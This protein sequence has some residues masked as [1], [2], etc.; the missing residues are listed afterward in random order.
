[1]QM[2]YELLIKTPVDSIDNISC[3]TVLE[4]KSPN[5]KLFCVVNANNSGVLFENPV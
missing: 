4:L 5:T 3:W 1:M 2:E